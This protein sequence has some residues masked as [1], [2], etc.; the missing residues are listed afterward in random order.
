MATAPPN[1]TANRSS[2]KAP[3]TSLVLKTKFNPSFTLS[4]VRLLVAVFLIGNF[5]SRLRFSNDKIT[6]I[7]ITANVPGTPSAAI[8]KPPVACPLTD[9]IKKVPWFQVMAFCKI[10]LGT[11]C[12]NIAGKDGPT[13]ALIIP[14]QK[15]TMYMPQMT[16]FLL[17]FL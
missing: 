7:I 5:V 2:D 3:N 15:I 9:A 13:K 8:Q 11:I 1:N 6:N 4:S 16:M 12:P 10:F 17:P 14:V